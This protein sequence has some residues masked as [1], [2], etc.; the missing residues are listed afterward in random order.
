MYYQ[1]LLVFHVSSYFLKDPQKQFPLKGFYLNVMLTDQ[2]MPGQFDLWSKQI[3]HVM[4]P[5][6]GFWGLFP[7]RNHSKTW[8]H[9][10][11]ES[12]LRCSQMAER[13][14]YVSDWPCIHLYLSTGVILIS[15][16]CKKK[17][18]IFC[19][20]RTKCCTMVLTTKLNRSLDCC[21]F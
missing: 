9:P 6:L 7:I 15:R 3:T 21:R 17:K 14:T 19:T 5:K 8:N 10:A 16:V 11:G 18:V 4:M 12:L 13:A 1:S 2:S 20:W